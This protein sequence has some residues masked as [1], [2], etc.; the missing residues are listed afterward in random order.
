MGY[1][2]TRVEHK[3]SSN[4]YCETEYSILNF[5]FYYFKKISVKHAGPLYIQLLLSYDLVAAFPF[6]YNMKLDAE[7]LFYHI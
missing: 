6:C 5:G 3:P 2:K 1:W 4:L 7:I